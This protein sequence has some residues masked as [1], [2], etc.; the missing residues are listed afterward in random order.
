MKRARLVASLARGVALIAVYFALGKLGLMVASLNPSATAVWPPTGIALAALLVLGR[1]VWP[2]ILLGAFLVNVTTAG[3]VATSLCIA[4]GNT[5]EGLFGAYLVDRYANGRNAFGK[6]SDVFRFVVLAGM[7][8]TA[9]SATFGV[10]S[11]A[12]AGFVPWSGY[13]AVWVTWWLGDAA[14]ALLVAPLLILWSSD[15]LPRWSGARVV[16]AMLLLFCV[17]LVGAVVLGGL[18]PSVSRYP[19]PYVCLPLL[20][21]S[22]FRFGQRETVTA[23][24]LLSCIAT[25]GAVRGAGPFIAGTPNESLL[26][27]QAF[28][29]VTSIVAMSLAALVSER[30]RAQEAAVERALELARSN[31]ELEQYAYVASHDLQ[32]P[33]RMVTSFVQLL[34]RRYR[35]RLDADADDF[36]GYIVDGATRMRHLIDDLLAFSRASMSVKPLEETDSGQLLR[37]AIESLRV[38][39]KETGATVSYGE[40]PKVMGDASQLV[41]VFENLIG[42]AIKFRGEEP[43]EIH[44]GA[45]RRSGE[46]LFLVQ[47][48]GIGIPSEHA[49]RIFA[50]FQRLHGRDK[51]PGSGI[52]LAIC[53]KIISRHGGRIWVEPRPGEGSRFCFT[54]PEA[55]RGAASAADKPAAAIEARG[56]AAVLET[57]WI[58]SAPGGVKRPDRP[59]SRLPGPEPSGR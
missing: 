21:W 8:S 35:G 49:E 55:R 29:G 19:L 58:G 14:G 27:L 46:W 34:A 42:N 45:E 52:G 6:S 41:Q 12:L 3:T 32:E 53:H 26:L 2:A 17:V 22:A 43:P 10:S 59:S 1:R 39:I 24:F 15:P 16:E 4:L 33:L 20:I 28:M 47:D 57:S 13:D 11:L 7:M 37:E 23:S 56:G 5:L 9:V 51:Y 31:A 50:V 36:I 25:W 30:R 40:M 44:V 38:S 18:I 48:N 54:L